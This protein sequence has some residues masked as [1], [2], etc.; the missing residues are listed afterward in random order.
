[1]NKNKTDPEKQNIG[2]KISA[3]IPPLDDYSSRKE[4]EKAAWQKLLESKNLLVLLITAN[5]RHRLTMRAAALKGLAAG[6]RQRQLSREL[7]LSLQTIN[8]VKKALSENL[9]QSYSER[10][11]KER[12][13]RKYSASLTSSKP[14]PKGFPRR[15]KYGTIRLPY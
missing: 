1:M 2:S 10:S 14:K 6:K 5:E 12:K 9:Y 8:S 13:K 4:W 3:I 7:F 11:K 15:T